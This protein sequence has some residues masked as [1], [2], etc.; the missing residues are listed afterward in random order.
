MEQNIFNDDFRDF[1]QALNKAKVKYI[2]VGGYSVILHGFSRSTGDMDIWVEPSSENY[3][4]LSIAFAKFGLPI[5]EM[6]L[7]KFL[8][9]N[10]FDVFTFGRPPV[11]IDIM[12]KLKGLNFSA[13]FQLSEWLELG[14]DFKV[15]VLSLNDLIKAKKAA[16]RLKDLNDIDHLL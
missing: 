3:K 15:R 6:S 13:A 5:F 11:A 14:D 2:L 16:G 12:T 10:Q 8:N 9:T 1:I 7:E 4:K